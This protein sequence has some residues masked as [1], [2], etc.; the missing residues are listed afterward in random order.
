MICSTNDLRF[1]S[2]A[3]SRLS[4]VIS[5]DL[6]PVLMSAVAALI[7][8]LSFSELSF[9]FSLSRPIRIE[10]FASVKQTSRYFSVYLSY[11]S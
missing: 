11:V 5:C 3:S 1:F 4:T 9:S 7:W 6:M 8:S 2:S 10:F